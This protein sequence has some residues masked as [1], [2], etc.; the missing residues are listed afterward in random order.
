MPRTWG[1]DTMGILVQLVETGDKRPETRDTRHET[2]DQSLVSRVSC[3]ASQTEDS[4]LT[5]DFRPRRFAVV[6]NA[7]RTSSSGK[8]WLING[9]T[10]TMPYWMS[11]SAI[12]K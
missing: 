5:I 2:R 12:V 10:R 7:S 4:I 11:F 9:A 8:R 6:S 1:A 3:L